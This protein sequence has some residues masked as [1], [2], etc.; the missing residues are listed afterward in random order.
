[1]DI[2]FKI[3]AFIFG[4]FIGSFLNVVIYR[5]PLKKSLVS[6]RSSCPH[7]GYMIP[8]YMNIPILG[9]VFLLGKC[10]QCKKPIN[11]RYPLIEL[12]MGVTALYLLPS[13]LNPLSLFEFVF[14]FSI[15]SILVCHF[16]IDLDHFLLL[17]SLNLYLLALIVPYVIFF[18]HYKYWLIGGAI[19]FLMPM[20]VT[21]AFYKIRGKIGLGG[22]DIKLWGIF[23][24]Y[25]GPQGVIMNIFLSCFVGALVGL[26]L[27]LIKKMN[28]DTPLPFGPFIIIVGVV[29]IFFPDL[30][31]NLNSLLF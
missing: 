28:K 1:M 15:F 11:F 30:L 6:P 7:C 17:D 9:Y 29:Q 2:L 12:L 13:D 24:L 22:G 5:L 16:F 31:S 27:M 18:H 8:W 20:F 25:L 23:G 10:F 21:W 14:L 3:Y 19:G 4:S 26:A